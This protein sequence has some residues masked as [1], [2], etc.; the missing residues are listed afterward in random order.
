MENF[1]EFKGSKMSGSMLIQMMPL[2]GVM[3]LFLILSN[4]YF[5]LGGV[6]SGSMEPTFSKGDMLLLQ[7]IDKN[8]KI[9]DIVMFRQYGIKEPIT[10]RAI[11]ITED[12]NII[13]KGDANNF[14]DNPRGISP[15]RIGAKAVLIFGKPILLK[16]IGYY[17]KP[18]S[19][20]GFEV[21]S[22]LPNNIVLSRTF[23][24]FRIVSP[25]IL[26]FCTI[27]YF[28]VLIETKLNFDRKFKRTKGKKR[29]IDNTKIE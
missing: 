4:Q 21:L 11:K 7:R 18:E 16:E 24:Q 9:G 14:L 5:F 27:F 3:A 12:G 15:E 23:D 17:L 6:I 28:F 2:F 26:F 29:V 22:R 20:G 1:R 8:V 10:H 13:T 19:I 25:M